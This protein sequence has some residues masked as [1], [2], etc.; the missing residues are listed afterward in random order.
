VA[1]TLGIGFRT[2]QRVEDGTTGD[3][4]PAKYAH[5]VK[6]LGEPV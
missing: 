5:M 1:A 6:G 4:V 3:R 2:L